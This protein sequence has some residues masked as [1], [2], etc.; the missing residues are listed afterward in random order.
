P[1]TD[2]NSDL[3]HLAEHARILRLRGIVRQN[4]RVSSLGPELICKLAGLS[5][6]QLYRSFEP[7]GGVGHYIQ[8]E[9]LRRVHQAL[10]DPNEHRNIASI[11]EE[12]GYSDPNSFSRIFRRSFGYSATHLRNAA[13]TEAKDTT[14][15]ATSRLG[16]ASAWSALY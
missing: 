11:A 9:R 1:R 7:F 12:Y 2:I 5:R 14:V 16:R 6:T 8:Q 13:I 4:L 15:V 3:R 10:T